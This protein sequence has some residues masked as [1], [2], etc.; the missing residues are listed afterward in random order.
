M[1]FTKIHVTGT[2][3]DAGTSG[4]PEVHPGGKVTF[5]LNVPA[6]QNTGSDEII[7]AI[8]Y[9]ANLDGSGHFDIELIAND[10]E[11]TI[12]TGTSYDVVV[13]ITGAAPFKFSMVVASDS[14]AID[15][16]MVDF[17][18]VPP[19]PL[20]TYLIAI[21][22][23]D[24]SVTIV[25][26]GNV[27]DL[28]AAPSFPVR[29]E[30]NLSQTAP[31]A[32]AAG[33]DV[34]MVFTEDAINGAAITFPD[35][36]TIHC[37]DAG[38]YVIEVVFS[39]TGVQTNVTLEPQIVT[40]STPGWLSHTGPPEVLMGPNSG[41]H[42]TFILSV[43]AGADIEIHATGFGGDDTAEECYVDVFRIG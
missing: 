41:T 12:P 36:H 42:Q 23:D 4:D 28:S 40:G 25:Q 19:D 2:F 5:T 18:F 31:Q 6:L 8:P 27:V 38:I 15:L 39:N 22:S 29:S 14:G 1:A 26:T 43:D 20:N 21:T 17:G 37:V 24:A 30:L 10:D 13:A 35:D 33:I 7:S 11:D 32:M 34:R 16:A 9:V 3:T